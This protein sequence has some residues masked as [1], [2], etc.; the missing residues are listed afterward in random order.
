V[1]ATNESPLESEDGGVD[2]GQ[3]SSQYT[4]ELLRI[5]ETFRRPTGHKWPR[6]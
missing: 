5:S 3:R 4:L 6:L 2:S 1:E